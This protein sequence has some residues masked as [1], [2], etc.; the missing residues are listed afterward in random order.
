MIEFDDWLIVEPERTEAIDN[1]RKLL[2][3]GCGTVVVWELDRVVPSRN[4]AG[5]WAQGD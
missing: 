2:E 3:D 5:G 1:A 4:A